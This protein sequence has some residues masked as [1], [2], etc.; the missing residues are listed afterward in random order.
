MLRTRWKKLIL[1]E[2]QQ[3]NKVNSTEVSVVKGE[4]NKTMEPNT[5]P[6]NTVIHTRNPEVS[7]H[8]NREKM[9]SFT[10]VET[11]GY[12]HGGNIE[13]FPSHRQRPHPGKL[14]P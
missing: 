10:D 2:T 7:P 9:A 6:R 13:V 5:E 11:T 1:L 3:N 14:R 12:S 4:T 8:T